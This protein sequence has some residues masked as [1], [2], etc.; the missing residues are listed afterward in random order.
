MSVY[1]FLKS[2]LCC[3]AHEFSHRCVRTISSMIQC[4]E[5]NL[6]GRK[7]KSLPGTEWIDASVLYHLWF[8]V[9]NSIY[10]GVN[11]NHFLALNGWIVPHP[12]P[13]FQVKVR[14]R[15]SK[16]EAQKASSTSYE[17]FPHF[18]LVVFSTAVQGLAQ[19]FVGPNDS[20]LLT[21]EKLSDVATVS[22]YW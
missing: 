11:W 20:S 18:P 8:S 22:V 21:G 7:L 16:S 10:V 9:L 17:C 4:T 5:F 19:H 6:C 13:S 12:G 15:R 1:D 2:S 3:Y 14:K